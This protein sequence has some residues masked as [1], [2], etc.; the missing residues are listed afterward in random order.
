MTRTKYDWKDAGD[1]TSNPEDYPADRYDDDEDDGD[2][3]S[4]P[5]GQDT[6]TK[7]AL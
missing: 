6:K 3:Q 2:S 5:A 1:F 7:E 4:S